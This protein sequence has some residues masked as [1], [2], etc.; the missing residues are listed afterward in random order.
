MRNI[1]VI[2]FSLILMSDSTAQIRGT[3]W[4]SSTKDMKDGAYINNLNNSVVIYSYYE[5]FRGVEVPVSYSFANDKLA[6]ITLTISPVCD[7][8]NYLDLVHLIGTKY[9]DIGKIQY[10]WINETFKGMNDMLQLAIDS[11]HVELSKLWKDSETLSK[12]TINLT[13]YEEKGITLDYV[14]TELMGEY[15]SALTDDF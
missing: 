15:N 5:L 6:R 3:E 8:K 12:T 9:Y 11:K 14:S 4:G 10:N 7:L 2:I 13:C 1:L